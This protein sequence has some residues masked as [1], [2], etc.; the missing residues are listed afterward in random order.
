MAKH[1]EDQ[2]QS[3]QESPEKAEQDHGGWSHCRSSPCHRQQGPSGLQRTM[4]WG[5]GATGALVE[6]SMK[7]TSE[8]KKGAGSR[9]NGPGL[10]MVLPAAHTQEIGFQMPR[11]HELPA[12]MPG[13]GVRGGERGM[14]SH[15]SFPPHASNKRM[16]TSTVLIR[17][18]QTF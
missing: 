1:P 5:Y 11:A 10:G 18:L 13:G 16:A 9:E 2:M 12:G 3:P 17:K 7:N 15:A 14:E 8:G 4:S 6:S